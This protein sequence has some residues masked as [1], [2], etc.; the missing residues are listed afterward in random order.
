[1]AIERVKVATGHNNAVGFV[2]FLV[3]PWTANILPGIVRF[4][5]SLVV[6]RDGL[7]SAELRWVPKVPD[8]VNQDVRAKCGLTGTTISALVTA[9]L[10][11]NANRAT[12]SNFNATAYLPGE[13]EYERKGWS[14]L[15]VQLLFLEPI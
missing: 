1:M 10:P 8:W 12:F 6:K 9:R 4:S 13:A 11:D 2:E 5:L 15:V 14:G 3:D 7:R